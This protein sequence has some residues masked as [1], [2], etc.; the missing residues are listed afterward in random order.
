MR[1]IREGVNGW[2]MIWLVIVLI[3]V[4][5]L[6]P[7]VAAENVSTT[8]FK[9]AQFVLSWQLPSGGWSKHMPDIYHRYWDGREAQA[10]DYTY[11]GNVPIG[12]IDNG[13]TTSE[14]DFLIGVYAHRQ[15]EEIRRG[16][17]KG[18]D[19]L[20]EMQYESGGFPQVYPA[21]DAYSSQYENDV[22]FNDDAM[23]NVLTLFKRIVDKEEGYDESLVDTEL[24]DNVKD[25]FNRGIDYIIKSQIEV[26]GTK[27]IWCGQHDPYNYEPKMG[28]AFE[29]VSLM[30]RESVGIVEFLESLDS[31]DAEIMDAID[32]AALWFT[33]TAVINQQYVPRGVGGDYYIFKTGEL[34]WYRFYDIEKDTPLFAD[35]DGSLAQDIY[36]IKKEIRNSYG[37]AGNWASAIYAEYNDEYVPA[38]PRI[39][40]DGYTVAGLSSKGNGHYKFVES[41]SDYIR[42][43]SLQVIEEGDVV[44]IEMSLSEKN[45]VS[46]NLYLNDT[47]LRSG[48][49]EWRIGHGIGEKVIEFKVIK[50]Y[51]TS[52]QFLEF[53]IKGGQQG[54]FIKVGQLAVF[55]NGE[56]VLQ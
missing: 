33:K 13:M 21:Q 2:L 14:I 46:S 49:S 16:I 30:T 38:E 7:L 44:R 20:L 10:Y 40:E 28:R 56:E 35:K 25:A 17:Y 29:P 52:E 4:D 18:I 22:T 51:E 24:Y 1:K 15:D 55:V 9:K 27:K 48:R 39:T 36:D 53:E 54:E 6:G 8:D 11:K 37:W 45:E 12:T 32:S 5:S 34:M 41:G 43:P 42:T 47:G 50:D 19:F 23:V 26:D 31:D 3:A